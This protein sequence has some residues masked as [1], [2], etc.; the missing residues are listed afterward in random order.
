MSI[1]F[2]FQLT[3]LT[4]SSGETGWNPEM[5]ALCQR[6]ARNPD[7]A[8]MHHLLSDLQNHASS[9][10]FLNPVNKDEVTDYYEVIKEPMDLSTMEQRLEENVYENLDAFLNDASKIFNNCKAYNGENSS[11]TKNAIRLE[12]Y[13]KERV[14]AWKTD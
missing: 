2:Y 1:P 6:P 5:D 8:V 10:A 13:L 9:W 3:F 12:K 11:Y 14:Q 4:K 7:F